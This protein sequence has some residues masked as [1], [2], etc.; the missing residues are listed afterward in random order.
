MENR[1]VISVGKTI[2]VGFALC[3]ATRTLIMDVGKIWIDVAL[4]TNSIADEYSACGALS[5]SFAERIPY[6]VATP[7]MP[8]ILTEAFMQTASSVS[9]SSVLNRRFATGFNHLETAR[10][11]PLCSHTFISPSH[12]AYVARSDKHSDA[13]SDEASKSVLKKICGLEHKRSVVQAKKTSVK[14]IFIALLYAKRTYKMIY[15]SPKKL[16]NSKKALL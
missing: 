3:N 7:E 4:I 11:T 2:S 13:L 5:R 16:Y 9:L 1:L 15:F 8:S 6:G 12:T 10:E 14:R